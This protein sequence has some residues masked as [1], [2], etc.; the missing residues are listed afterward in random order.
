MQFFGGQDDS[1][2]YNEN[3]ILFTGV[4]VLVW[5]CFKFYGDLFVDM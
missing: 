2:Q 3:I 5:L 4:V 1:E